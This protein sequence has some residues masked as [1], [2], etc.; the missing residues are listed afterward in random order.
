MFHSKNS[1][2]IKVDVS[3]NSLMSFASFGWK[4]KWFGDFFFFFCNS[5]PFCLHR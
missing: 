5:L 4:L 1:L 3:I 2:E